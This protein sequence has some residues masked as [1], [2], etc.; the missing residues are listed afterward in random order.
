MNKLFIAALAVA[1]SGCTIVPFNTASKACEMLNIAADEADLAP[2][3]YITAG[4]VLETCGYPNAKQDAEDRACDAD[5]RNGYEC[6][7][8]AT[9]KEPA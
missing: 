2:Q 9:A 1:I 8:K 6:T 4:E 3:W 7:P 5:K